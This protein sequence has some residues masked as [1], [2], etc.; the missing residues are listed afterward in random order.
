MDELDGAI[1]VVFYQGTT[2]FLCS[3]NKSLPLQVNPLFL[4]VK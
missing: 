1:I 3:K 4:E 2:D